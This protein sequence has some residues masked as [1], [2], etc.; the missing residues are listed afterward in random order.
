[1]WMNSSNLHHCPRRRGYYHIWHMR[2]LKQE[3]VVTHPG[4]HISYMARVRLEAR[5]T[6]CKACSLTRSAR[7][8]V[9]KLDT[10][11]LSGFS[12]V[13]RKEHPCSKGAFALVLPLLSWNGKPFYCHRYRKIRWPFFPPSYYSPNCKEQCDYPVWKIFQASQLINSNGA[14][15]P[16]VT[17]FRFV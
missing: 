9:G 15:M 13:D 14:L 5:K 8:P 17:L 7:L 10:V 16:F 3:R 6:D 4:F 12:M 2:T 1:M 11:I